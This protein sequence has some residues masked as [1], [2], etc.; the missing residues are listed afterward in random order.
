MRLLAFDAIGQGCSA[1]CFLDGAPVSLERFAGATGQAERLVP[2]LRA[3]LGEAGWSLASLD[4]LAVSVGPGSFTG[5]RTG[6]AAARGLA[7]AARLPVWPVTAFAALALAA[8][9]EARGRPIAVLLD[10][11]R[12]QIF[13]QRF[14]AR[15]EA[16]GE[17]WLTTPDAAAALLDEP[18]LLAG[19]GA[20][21]VLPLLSGEGF[22]VA[23]ARLD[24]AAVV[25]AAETAAA[26]GGAPSEGTLVEPL[27]LRDSGA[28]PGAGRP[29][30]GA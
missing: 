18:H 9:P 23:A 16:L 28:R 15:A 1:G 29:L 11:R 27:Y 21:P 22:A 24:A 5:I 2:M 30:V 3:V 6:L 25:L 8:S 4:G 17:P 10:A 20:E 14:S 26:D 19:S 7:L 13:G 12:G